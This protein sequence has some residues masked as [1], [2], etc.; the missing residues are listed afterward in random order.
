[1]W[2]CQLIYYEE[3][4]LPSQKTSPHTDLRSLVYVRR[5]FSAV[6]NLNVP[7]TSTGIIGTLEYTEINNTC[8]LH[9]REKKCDALRVTVRRPPLRST[10]P[11]R[12][13]SEVE[14]I[15]ISGF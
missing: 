2:L 8:S 10:F 14:G 4:F 11:Y 15:L 12:L 1:M 9:S 7:V 6:N 3:F 13:N 5:V